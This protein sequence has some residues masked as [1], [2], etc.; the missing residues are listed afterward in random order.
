MGF[1]AMA[2]RR[3]KLQL[4]AGINTSFGVTNKAKLLVLIF[5]NKTKLGCS[6]GLDVQRMPPQQQAL[7]VACNHFGDML[8][9]VNRPQP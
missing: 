1:A 9:N 8:S 5:N 3:N 2:G 6:F 7:F 4:S